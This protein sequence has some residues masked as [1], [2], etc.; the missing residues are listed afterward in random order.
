LGCGKVCAWSD[1]YFISKYNGLSGQAEFKFDDNGGG[2]WR[3]YNEFSF[4]KRRGQT[5]EGGQTPIFQGTWKE[6]HLYRKTE[7]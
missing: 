3:F 5:G 7:L 1:Q 2:K 6:F 4:Y